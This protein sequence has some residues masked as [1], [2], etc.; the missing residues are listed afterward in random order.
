MRIVLI[1]LQV[2][3]I[4]LK[5]MDTAHN[6]RGKPGNRANLYKC[7]CNCNA[8]SAT[9]DFELYFWE[10]PCH[11]GGARVEAL[12]GREEATKDLQN[13]KQKRLFNPIFFLLLLQITCFIIGYVLT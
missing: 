4:G 7:T 13:F 10:T 1:R 12:A 5:T 2:R 9:V 3:H 6:R 8:M 11:C